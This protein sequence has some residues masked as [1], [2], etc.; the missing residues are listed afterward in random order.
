MLE[1]LISRHLVVLFMILIF[2]ILLRFRKS[3]R[4][5]EA[6]YFWLTI[7][8]CLLL[9]VEDILETKTASDPALRFW[10]ILLSVAGYTLRSTAILGL[11]LVV[12]TR[13]ERVEGARELV[14]VHHRLV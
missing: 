11:L 9:V 1:N 12:I 5:M 8:S 14:D 3:F 7:I 13:F 10:R 6:K 2:S 4:D